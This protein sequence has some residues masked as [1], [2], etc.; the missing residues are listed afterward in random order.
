MLD[1]LGIQCRDSTRAAV[2][3][4]VLALL[5]GSRIMELMPGVIGYGGAD[6][7]RDFW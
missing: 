2:D 6:A 7:M 1:P 4:A 5:G 3:D